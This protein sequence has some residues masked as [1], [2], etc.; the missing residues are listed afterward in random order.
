MPLALAFIVLSVAWRIAALYVPE[1]SNFAPLMAL[2]FCGAVYFRDKRLW[3]VPFVALTLSDLYIDY[4]YATTL[5]YEWAIGGAVLRAAC[6]AAA[7]GFGLMVARQRTWLN[8]FSGA[9]GGS[10]FFYL[11]TNTA[12]WIG[13]AAYAHTA[14][15]WWQ[16]MTV[17]H[18]QFAPT[19]WF[20]RNTLAS[21]LAF[22][23][24]FAVTMEYAALRAGRE[25]LL[26]KQATA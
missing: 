7:I 20:F 10:V 26:A 3:L 16:A 19:L 4:Y 25:S 6:F 11:V 15:G 24:V 17:G 1:L 18:P 14:A 9:L 23:A 13:D 8:V 2:T 12:S 5:H 22:T 21:D